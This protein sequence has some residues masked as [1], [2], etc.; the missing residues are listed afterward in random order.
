MT[1]AQI[2]S[3]REDQK[4]QRAINPTNFRHSYV[5]E[6]SDQ[7]ETYISAKPIFTS[8]TVK[9]TIAPPNSPPHY[10]LQKRSRSL[11]FQKQIL[12]LL[13]MLLLTDAN[14]EVC[15]RPYLLDRFLYENGLLR[16]LVL[17]GDF[18]LYEVDLTGLLSQI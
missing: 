2:Q 16:F 18:D 5:K 8:V 13:L 1:D 7:E 14:W 4:R 17:S 9:A 11:R 12:K 3:K 10:P 6:L 15:R